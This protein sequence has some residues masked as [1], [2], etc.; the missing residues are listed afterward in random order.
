MSAEAQTS[1]ELIGE[2]T[3]ELMG[4]LG[5]AEH[6]PPIAALVA[7]WVDGG[8]WWRVHTNDPLGAEDPHVAARLAMALGD[9]ALGGALSGGEAR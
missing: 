4:E 9:A 2:L 1:S 6:R 7:V 3:A 5:V 8:V